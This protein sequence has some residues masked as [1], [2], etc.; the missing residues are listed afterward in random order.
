VWP[1][2]VAALVLLVITVLVIGQ[3]PR[4][5]FLAVGWFWFAGM[6]LPVSGIVQVGSHSM[7]DRYTYVPLTGL[8]MMVA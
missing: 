7:A 1:A 3:A 4:R 5:R 2:I 8:F 6:L